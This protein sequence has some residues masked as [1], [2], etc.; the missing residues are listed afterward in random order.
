MENQKF[1]EIKKEYIKYKTKCYEDRVCAIAD[2]DCSMCPKGI[3]LAEIKEEVSKKKIG[4][5]DEEFKKQIKDWVSMGRWNK[6]A[7]EQ[8]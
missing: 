5:W 1:E 7:V 2:L 8:D 4:K 3:R 6:K